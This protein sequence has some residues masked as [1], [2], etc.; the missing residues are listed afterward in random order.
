VGWRDIITAP[1]ASAVGVG[2]GAPRA[3]KLGY[4]GDGVVVAVLDTGVEETH[5]D[6]VDTIIVSRNF[7]AAPDGDQDGHS[8]RVATREHRGR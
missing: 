7:M 2:I 3:W 4:E 6:L 8:L 1:P 5:P